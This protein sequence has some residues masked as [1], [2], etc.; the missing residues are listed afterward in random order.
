VL[1]SPVAAFWYYSGP[2]GARGPG[3]RFPKITGRQIAAIPLPASHHSEIA[4]LVRDRV[5]RSERESEALLLSPTEYDKIAD[6]ERQIDDKV[7]EAFGL[8]QADKAIIDRVMRAVG[9][10]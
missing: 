4:H 8:S 1:C 2:A 7:A 9:R 3:A 5:A 10:E 6:L